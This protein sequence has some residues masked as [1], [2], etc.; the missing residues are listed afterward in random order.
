M[1]NSIVA[2]YRIVSKLGE[3][4][5][6]VV[7]RATDTKLQRDVA[8]KFLPE[9]LANDPGRRSRFEREA[10]VLAALN[11]PH[12]AAVYGLED[13]A[14]VM[15]LVE[16][17]TLADRIA[18]GPIPLDE[19]L[20]IARQ[21][22]EAMEA[23]HEKGIV[24]RDLK[25]ANV[26]LTAD[27][28]VKVLD[29]GLAKALEDPTT[30]PDSNP[31]HSPTLVAGR[32]LPGLI[33]GTASYMSPEQARGSAVDKRTD[34][35][36]FG[37]VL[38]EMLT[39]KQLFTGETISDTLAQVLTKEP[40]LSA[41]PPRVRPMLERCLERDR[42]KRL[43]DI[44]DA[45]GIQ[46]TAPAPILEVRRSV[47]WWWIIPAVALLIA[48]GAI[49]AWLLRTTSKLPLRAF[50]FTPKDLPN[51]GFGNRAA[52]SPDGKYVAYVAV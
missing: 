28:Q 51:T 40:D 47:P 21:I 27:G 13:R 43:R 1:L 26:K 3:G 39:A 41:I 33:L 23:A 35:W 44:G 36:A 14:I 6:G 10:Q 12:I 16:G 24:H 48:S 11:H 34:I 9:E 2:H 20:E 29:F 15:E 45:F 25:P 17:P 31:A 19:A 38:Y 49:A 18:A 42:K 52:I 5:M 30:A 46:E 37:V 8:L 7:Y 4:G 50:S 32:S 22:A